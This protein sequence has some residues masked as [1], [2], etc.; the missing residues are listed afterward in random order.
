MTVTGDGYLSRLKAIKCVAALALYQKIGF[1]E[2][3][4][5]RIVQSAAYGYRRCDKHLIRCE[6]DL[7]GRRD[8]AE[9]VAQPGRPGPRAA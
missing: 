8:E 6:C 4:T 5:N 1:V 9:G 7:E 2:A 3:G